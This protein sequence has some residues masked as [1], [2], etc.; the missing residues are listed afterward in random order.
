MQS[1]TTWYK[2]AWTEAQSEEMIKKRRRLATGGLPVVLSRLPIEIL[3]E[4]FKGTALR[5]VCSET[6][7]LACKWRVDPKLFLNRNKDWMSFQVMSG[8]PVS[9]DHDPHELERFILSS[10]NEHLI[11]LYRY[12]ADI[13]RNVKRCNEAF[14]K[15]VAVSLAKSGDVDSLKRLKAR[16]S[17]KDIP[18]SWGDVSKNAIEAATANNQCAVLGLLKAKPTTDLVEIAVSSESVDS[19]VYFLNN[20]KA[21]KKP[22][23]LL[24]I[25]N[26]LKPERILA[27]EARMRE[28]Y[29]AYMSVD[30]AI[31]RGRVDTAIWFAVSGRTTWRGV[32]K[33]LMNR[34][35]LGDGSL[36]D[37]RR[38]VGSGCAYSDDDFPSVCLFDT[39]AECDAIAGYCL[40]SGRRPSDNILRYLMCRGMINILDA[41][42]VSI[43]L[44]PPATALSTCMGNLHVATIL[45]FKKR[46]RRLNPIHADKVFTEMINH[47]NVESFKLLYNYR[48]FV[49][50]TLMLEKAVCA[51]AQFIRSFLIS[52]GHK[53][54][55][56]V[57]CDMFT[58]LTETD[59]QNVRGLY[60]MFDNVPSDDKDYEGIKKCMIACRNVA[61]TSKHF[62]PY[63]NV[64]IHRRVSALCDHL[65]VNESIDDITKLCDDLD[66]EHGRNTGK[67]CTRHR[68]VQLIRSRFKA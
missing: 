57:L 63:N 32:L 23:L 64:D 58:S 35:C 1:R 28:L 12:D 18:C 55:S 67:R 34:A 50:C 25:A 26:G 16:M 39:Q 59:P 49:K 14:H 21:A 52:A 22:E 51:G 60:W 20:C 47:D 15:N 9:N 54:D 40:M 13:P 38:A 45:W 29:T 37:V 10:E 4:H 17:S 68:C 5:S 43:G 42:Y 11:D 41:L 33:A 8:V 36:D 27:V 53:H 7:D 56:D 46:G 19:C 44:I 61:E 2:R 62:R 3:N 31:R 30:I 6:R 65:A 48:Y 24:I 66:I